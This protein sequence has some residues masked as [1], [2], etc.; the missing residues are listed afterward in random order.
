M[1]EVSKKDIKALQE[2]DEVVVLMPGK[3][4]VI[5]HGPKRTVLYWLC[6]DVGM[7]VKINDSLEDVKEFCAYLMLAGAVSILAMVEAVEW[8]TWLVILFAPDSFRRLFKLNTKAVALILRELDFWVP[9]ATMCLAVFFASAS[10]GHEGAAAH[11]FVE[12]ALCFTVNVLLADA[13]LSKRKIVT[14]GSGTVKYFGILLG[15]I[16]FTILLTFDHFP[17]S[18]NHEY[19]FHF[20]NNRGTVEVVSLFARFMTT[21]LLFT[22]KFVVKSLVYKGRAV[23]IKI[24]LVR[25]VMPKRELRAF[26]RRRQEGRSGRLSCMR[27]G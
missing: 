24:L 9:F 1:G 4:F 15:M 21:P 23:I 13:D 11:F 25:N 17:R 20:I 3:E 5:S 27:V 19:Y 10:F 8:A 16:A 14:K 7:T 18:E 2:D 26:L 22:T 12:F 6:R